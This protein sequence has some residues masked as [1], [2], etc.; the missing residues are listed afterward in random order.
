MDKVINTLPLGD[1]RKMKIVSI[2]TL[3]KAVYDKL[4]P[5]FCFEALVP[6]SRE[7]NMKKVSRDIFIDFGKKKVS[8]LMILDER[9]ATRGSR[10]L[11]ATTRIIEVVTHVGDVHEMQTLSR[12]DSQKTVLT[13]RADVL[14][15]HQLRDVTKFQK[16]CSG[17]PLAIIIMAS[18]LASKPREAVMITKEQSIDRST[19]E[20]VTGAMGSLLPKLSQ[21]LKD[22]YNLQIGVRKKIESLSRELESVHAVLCI[23]GEVPSNQLSNLVKLWARDLREASYQMEDIIDAFLVRVDGPEPA[24][25]PGMLRRFKKKMCKRF[26]KSKHRHNIGGAIDDINEKLKEVAERRGRYTVDDIPKP[27]VPATI[28]P[29]LLSLYKKSSELVGIQGQMDKLMKMLCLSDDSDLTDKMVKMICIVGIG[30]L[31]K[32]T[33]AKAVYDKLKPD[34]DCGAFVLVGQNP[35]VKKVLRDIL[36]GLD[37]QMYMNSNMLSLDEKQLID[38]LQKFLQKKRCFIVIDDIWDK[39]SWQIFRCALQDNTGSRVITT[40]RNFD[41]ATHTSY[42]YKMQPLSRD[43][44][45]N[46]LY[47][48]VNGEGKCLDSPSAQACE[49]ILKKCGGVPLAIITIASLLANKPMEYWPEVYNSIGFL[50]EGNDDVENTRRILSLSYYDLPLHL[51][52]C[53]SYLSIFPEDYYIEKILL[54]WKWIAE[55]FIPEKQ[56]AK[57]GLFETGEGYFNELINRSMIQP[58]EDENSWCIDGCHVHDMVLDQIRVLSSEENFVTVIDGGEQHELLRK[59]CRRLALH[60]WSFQK[61]GNQ[62]ASIGVEQLRYLSVQSVPFILLPDEVGNLKFLQVLDLSQ[63]KILEL[64]VSVSLL[65]KLLCLRVGTYARVSPSVI[66]KLQSLQE[67]WIKPSSGDRWQ[68]VKA[69]GKLTELRILRI[70]YLRLDGLDE[71]SA[72][73]ESLLN[74]H[75]IH[76][77]EINDHFYVSEGVT[78]ESGFTCPQHLRYLYLISLKFHRMPVWINSSVL[79]NLFYLDLQVNVLDGQDIETL[80]RLPELRCLKLHTEYNGIVTSEKTVSD[81]YFRELRYFSTPYLCVRFDDLHGIMILK[82]ADLPGFDKLLSFTHIGR[83]SLETVEVNT[84]CSGACD[85]EVKEAEAALAHSAAI[86]P[87]HRTL[88]IMRF[89]QE[90]MLSP[91]EEP[92]SFFPKVVVENVNVEERNHDDFTIVFYWML[93]RN[94]CVEKFSISINC[95]NASL[96]DVERAEAAARFAVDVHANRPTLELMRYSEDKMVLSD[97]HQQ[98]T[99]EPKPH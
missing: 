95:E 90:K 15:A 59:N 48:R 20:L 44:S 35:D 46:L 83:N 69:L 93:K 30:G 4:K 52:P 13:V 74:L 58:V 79:P 29:R 11:A 28:D 57:L 14:I 64:P 33:L 53:L 41:V 9:R 65:T 60:H 5:V 86:H 62:L 43:D 45:E 16:I 40:T 89:W 80:G 88:R 98:C 76:T 7:P 72:L 22:E 96:E 23:I 71:T 21:L 55:G 18:L 36:S 50:H 82:D 56:A 94:P 54:I 87:N 61:N 38:E 63:T 92:S 84:Y 68:F 97:Q 85:E 3:A 6:V 10:A 34:F 73:L 2:V 12:D 77:M 32:T 66:G 70:E 17:V 39:K 78:W 25:D 91:H 27:A 67:I 75:K 37:K 42:I 47:D 24:A 1:D 99:E 26:N 8:D 81:G 51:K 49:K 31:G 19:M